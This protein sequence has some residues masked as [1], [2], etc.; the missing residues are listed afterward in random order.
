[1]GV[2]KVYQKSPTN[3]ITTYD[4]VDIASGL[5]YVDYYGT[6]V[7]NNSGTKSYSL[8]PFEV[9]T[10]IMD[11]SVYANYFYLSG[12]VGAVN[13]DTSSFNSPRYVKQNSKV[14]MTYWTNHGGSSSHYVKLKVQK[15]SGG[16]YVDISNEFSTMNCNSTTTANQKASAIVTISGNY[17]FKR[18]DN[19]R[20]VV[21]PVIAGGTATFYLD[22]N[23]TD[24]FKVSV[25]FK[26][27]Q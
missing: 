11:V 17:I 20:L 24:A 22:Y 1:M 13:F 5:G 16:S 6:G 21:T 9:K 18:G 27:T 12:V 23:T 14:Y 8:N 3:A 10:Q 7:E 2:N 25:P 4:W 26:I 19:L 15:G